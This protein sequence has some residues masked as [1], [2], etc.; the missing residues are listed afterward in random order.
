MTMSS[1]IVQVPSLLCNFVSQTFRRFRTTAKNDIGNMVRP[2]PEAFPNNSEIFPVP[3]HANGEYPDSYLCRTPGPA[4]SCIQ[5][6]LTLPRCGLVTTQQSGQT[7]R[8]GADW[9]HPA[10]SD[11]FQ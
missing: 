9:G 10:L 11:P 6:R 3:G 7:C 2:F 8:S 5:S 4:E 1:P